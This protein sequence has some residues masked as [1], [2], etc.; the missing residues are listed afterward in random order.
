MSEQEENCI[1]I[2]DDDLDDQYML[3]QD[4]SSLY[5]KQKVNAVSDGVELFDYLLKKETYKAIDAILSK[6]ILPDHNMPKKDDRECL[7]E[8][9]GLS[10]L[11]KYPL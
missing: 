8:L 2:A 7:L 9:K 6:V 10:E 1:L 11:K 3:K 5:I 4:F